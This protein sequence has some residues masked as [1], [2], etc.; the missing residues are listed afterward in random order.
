MQEGWTRYV[1]S[2]DIFLGV[3]ML[4]CDQLKNEQLKVRCGGVVFCIAGVTVSFRSFCGTRAFPCRV[5]R[6]IWWSASVI[7]SLDTEIA[8]KSISE[9]KNSCPAY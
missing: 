2:T 3:G 6:Q 9:F 8:C 4:T 1:A 5:R 7:G